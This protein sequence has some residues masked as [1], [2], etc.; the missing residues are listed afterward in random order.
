[1]KIQNNLWVGHSKNPGSRTW[2]SDKLMKGLTSLDMKSYRLDAEKPLPLPK[3]YT[4]YPLFLDDDIV[5]EHSGN[6]GYN[7]R[8]LL[9]YD[10]NTMPMIRAEIF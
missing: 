7:N 9:I 5:R 1:M 3:S 2:M 6:N 4:I 10:T 8:G